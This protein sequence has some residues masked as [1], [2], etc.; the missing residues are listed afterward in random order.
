MLKD[1]NDPRFIDLIQPRDKPQRDGYALLGV[2][3]DG[4]V[5]G[6][7]G[8]RDG[9]KAIRECFR[10]Y[11]VY[12]WDRDFELT[13]PIFDFGNLEI[14][15]TSIEAAHTQVTEE[16]QKIRRLGLHPIIMGGDHSITYAAVKAINTSKRLGIINFD[17]HLDLRE[18]YEQISSGTPFRRLI[19][20]EIIAPQD[21][22]EIGLQNFKNAKLYRTFAENNGICT[23]PLSQIRSQGIQT[24][25]DIISH[26]LFANV[27]DV[28]ISID[29]DVVDQ[30]YAPGVSNPSS[31]GMT[32]WEIVDI[33]RQ[34][35]TH[36]K[37]IG[38]DLVETSPQHDLQ[39]TTANL[40]AYLII[41]FIASHEYGK[42]NF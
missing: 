8:A 26:Q 34:I 12:D 23:I 13:A 6:R 3:F 4:A 31:Y 21:L 11:S 18:T 14:S 7:K 22:V 28:W 5:L 2:P 29:I 16:V 24:T 38:M 40:A 37:C 1:P 30:G 42:S 19:D 27:E 20:E 10:F 35:A 41:Q 15:V 32:P 33:I 39:G 25:I 17:A 9:P 36:K